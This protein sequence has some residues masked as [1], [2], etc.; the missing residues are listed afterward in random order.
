MSGKNVIADFVEEIQVKSSGYTA[1]FGG[2]TGG[3]INVI[4]KSGTNN[5]HGNALFNFEGSSLAGA[6]RPDAAS[7]IDQF[8]PRRVRHL[9]EG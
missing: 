9:S 2:A 3:V 1:E 7:G 4:T 6:R 5:W 8:R